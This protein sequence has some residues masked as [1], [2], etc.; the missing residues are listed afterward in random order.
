MK[1]AVK[2]A[3]LE[4]IIAH[5][6]EE[7]PREACGILTGRD[8]K[9]TVVYRM[10]NIERSPMRYSMDLKEQ[11]KV[12]KEL[13]SKNLEMVAI[14]HSHPNVEPY[15]S[16]HDMELA[17]HPG[18]SYVIVSIINSTPEVRSFTI[19]NGVVKEEEIRIEQ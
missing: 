5:T 16:F 11:F 12:A 14:Y 8:R 10:A 13:R 3:I 17:L 2:K 6:K 7:F 1:L 18:V 4:E 9:A 15:P 19:V